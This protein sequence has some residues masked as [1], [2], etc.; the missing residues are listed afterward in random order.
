MGKPSG[1][2]LNISK[3]DVPDIHKSGCLFSCAH[4]LEVCHSLVH[5]QQVFSKLLTGFQMGYRLLYDTDGVFLESME[6]PLECS[7][8]PCYPSFIASV[9]FSMAVTSVQR[10]DGL[11]AYYVLFCK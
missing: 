4:C 5:S 1:P 7:Q 11:H 3:Y 9:T 6:M 10:S 8:N 2:G